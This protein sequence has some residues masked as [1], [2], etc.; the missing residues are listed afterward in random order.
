MTVLSSV[1]IFAQNLDALVAFYADLFDLAEKT[2]LRSPIYRALDVGGT[3][4]GFNGF[5]AYKLLKL[6][7]FSETS[8]VKSLLTFEVAGA[9]E[10]ARISQESMKRGAKMI[11]EPYDTAYGSRQSVLFDPEGNVFRINAF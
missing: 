9:G 5:E 6:E 10:V 7:D 1:N 3:M 2:E 8:G 11:K 4:I